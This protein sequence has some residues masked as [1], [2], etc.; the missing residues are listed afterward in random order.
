MVKAAELFVIGLSIKFEKN[1]II[2]AKK[3]EYYD[4]ATIFK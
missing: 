3:I 2:T 1:I 4:T